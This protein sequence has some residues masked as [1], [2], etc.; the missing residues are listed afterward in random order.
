MLK[1]LAMIASLGP[2]GEHIPR[3][4]AYCLAHAIYH[5]SRGE[6]INGQIAVAH[7]IKNRVKSN[8]YPDS[9]C[10]VAYQPHQFTDIKKTKPNYNS[11]SWEI[12][13][14][15][16]GFVYIG[17]IDDNTKGSTHYYA[18]KKVKP[19][20]SKSLKLV[21]RIGDHTFMKEG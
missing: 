15:I 21:G 9:Y 19:Y 10:G 3:Q 4:E 1:I 2:L 16:A 20:W 17:F 18:H 13:V 11:E 5:E 7:V 6:S 12:A 14:E 8:R